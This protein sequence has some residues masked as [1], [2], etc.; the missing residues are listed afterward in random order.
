MKIDRRDFI[1]M[2][3]AFSLAGCMGLKPCASA[4]KRTEWKIGHYQVHFIYTGRSECMFHIF[5]DGTSMLLDCGD[6][7]RFYGTPAAVPVPDLSC[8]AGEAAARYV[9]QVNPKDDRVD[10]LHLSHYHEDHAGGMRYHGGILSDGRP[11]SGISDAARFLKFSRVVDRAWPEFDDPVDVVG[12]ESR[13]G[14]PRHM[15]LL[16]RHLAETQGTLIERFSLGSAS[17]FKAQ[18][19]EDFSVFNLCANGRYV[20][21]DG[22]VRDLYASQAADFR[23]GRRK[24]LNENALSCGM[25]IRYGK[26]SYFTA[27]D[28]SDGKRKDLK[29][30][31]IENELA[32]A[33]GPVTVA[34]MNHHAHHSMPS[35]LVKALKAKVWTNCT[36][37][38]QHCTDDSM[39]RMSS[40]A[41][42]EG[43]RILLPTYMP[44][45]RR[46]TK[47]GTSYL[48]DV[49]DCVRR[50][51]CHVICDVAP[52]GNECV[53]F[54]RDAMQSGNPVAGEFCIRL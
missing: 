42:Y 2:S 30:G 22:S 24:M 21:K 45:N 23:A 31:D 39:M 47:F 10:I 15:R 34:K 29:S 13:D 11:L 41:L 18:G 20:K 25:I 54:C 33:V 4:L 14:T 48:A 46:A 12:P 49:P 35:G 1:G 16:Y 38:Q 52:G 28:F 7:M 19:Y 6:S 50:R 9:R 17:Q 36:L 27:G 37:D 43:E 3:S 40:R 32:E 53:F 5:P 26:F 44:Q 51:P 8:R